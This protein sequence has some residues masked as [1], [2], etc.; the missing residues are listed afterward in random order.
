MGITLTDVLLELANPAVQKSF[1]LDPKAFLIGKGLSEHEADAVIT[2]DALAI[3]RLTRSVHSDDPTQQFNRY[4]KNNEVL[5]E[6]D[7]MLEQLH[8]HEQIAIADQLALVI[9]EEGR[10]YRA[11]SDQDEMVG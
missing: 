6:I 1:Q 4:T 9:D 11:V 5:I 3:G 10:L 2:A 8:E 7:L